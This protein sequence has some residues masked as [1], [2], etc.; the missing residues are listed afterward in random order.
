[1]NVQILESEF[2][3]LMNTLTYLE[4]RFRAAD[5]LSNEAYA[6]GQHRKASSNVNVG[7]IYITLQRALRSRFPLIFLKSMCAKNVR[8]QHFTRT[9]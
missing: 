9:Y 5:L 1:M 2:K 7:P 6:T 4:T 8:V 3:T